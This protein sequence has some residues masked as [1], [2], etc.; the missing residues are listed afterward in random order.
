MKKLFPLLLCI[1]LLTA[2]AIPY[3]GPTVEITVPVLRTVEYGSYGEY[4]GEQ[5]VYTY[6]SY[7]N[8]AQMLTYHKNQYVY[9]KIYTYDE[10]GNLVKEVTWDMGNWFNLDSYNHELPHRT[11]RTEYTYDDQNR[12]VTEAGESYGKRFEYSYIYDDEA[13]TQTTLYNGEVLWTTSYGESPWGSQPY[14]LI[15]YDDLGRPLRKGYEG[16]SQPDWREEWEYL[17]EN[18]SYHYYYNGSLDSTH[19]LDAQGNEIECLEYTYSGEAISYRETTVYETIR[20]RA[21]QEE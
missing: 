12:L 5:T 18:G 11:H 13:Q 3:H 1:L 16:E 9:K 10:Q 17:D 8:L 4:S 19:I 20:V 7:G 6:D 2:C 14:T 21:D 15:E